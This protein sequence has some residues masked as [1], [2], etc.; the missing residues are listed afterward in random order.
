MSLA[1]LEFFHLNQ[2]C[3]LRMSGGGFLHFL[4]FVQW[5]RRGISAV[6][7]ATQRKGRKAWLAETGEGLG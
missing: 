4:H 5:G 6:G 3:A 1:L 2:D 7:A